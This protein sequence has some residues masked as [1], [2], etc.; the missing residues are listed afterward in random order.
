MSPR[1]SPLLLAL[2]LVGC[3]PKTPPATNPTAGVPT[4]PTPVAAAPA[5]PAATPAPAAVPAE[6]PAAPKPAEPVGPDPGGKMAA[7]DRRVL[8]DA[9]AMLTTQ[10]PSKA[11]EALGR[12]QGL[13]GNYPDVAVVHYNMGLAYY[14]M[15]Q[16]DQARKSWLR[17]TEIDPAY[18]KGWL[19]LG[20]LSAIEKRTDMALASYQAGL[21]YAPDDLDLHVAAIGA[22]R[23]L[24]R[25]DDAIAEAKTA[26]RINSKAINVYN[27]LALVYIDT[28]QYDLAR[29]VLEKAKVDIQ[30]AEQNAQLLAAMGEVYLRLGY[31]GDALASFKKAL[32]IDPFQLAA[33]QFLANY[34]LD[35][36]SFDDATPLWE[37]VC[38][39]LP[40]EA[41][42][43]VNLGISYRGQKRYEDA[44]RAYEEALRLD[45]RNPE[46][47]RNLAVL[48]GDHMKAYD[49]AVQAIED[50]RKAGGGPTAELDAWITSL[51]KEQ[52]KAD[53]KRRREEEK[54]KR[55][56]A[57][58]AKAVEPAP[59]PPPEAPA[60]AQPQPAPGGDSPWGGGG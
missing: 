50:Y 7:N 13:A 24:K 33:L 26:L 6:A 42:P 14:F 10:D 53:D 12:L 30:G 11:Q 19:N 4:E 34:Y 5:T 51:R 15:G 17:S 18:A 22:L 1:V 49:A 20:N 56:E 35:N 45:P 38:G 47:L 44:K 59:A 55:E 28:K 40:M 21:R 29:F 32:D 58:K 43:R 39:R 3:G 36:H 46:P 23:Q 2:A 8:N 25:Y 41:G 54:R 16:P 9:V 60:P 57:E 31:P 52:K 37:R 27:Q 48:Y